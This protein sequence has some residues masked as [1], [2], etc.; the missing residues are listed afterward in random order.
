[1]EKSNQKE[2]KQWTCD[3]VGYKIENVSSNFGYTGDLENQT[4]LTT[5]RS[6]IQQNI[7]KMYEKNS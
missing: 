7:I 6:V 5:G 1:M 3:F 4:T 2:Q